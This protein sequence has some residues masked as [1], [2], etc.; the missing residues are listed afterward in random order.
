MLSK[1]L[2]CVANRSNS[3]TLFNDCTTSNSA[4][5][6]VGINC[7]V[8]LSIYW[9]AN[10]NRISVT[11]RIVRSNHDTVGCRNNWYITTLRNIDSMVVPKWTRPIPRRYIPRCWPSEWPA[12]NRRRCWSCLNWIR[13]TRW[14]RASSIIRAGSFCTCSSCS[15]CCFCFSLLLKFCLTLLF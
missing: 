12:R 5:A 13:R 10:K 2:S 4:V 15:S 9:M 6:H 8:N 14:A 11:R 1:R 7:C 3:L